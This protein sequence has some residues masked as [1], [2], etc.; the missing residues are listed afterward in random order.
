MTFYACDI[1]FDTI[2]ALD[3]HAHVSID[4][5]GRRWRTDEPGLSIQSA[6]SPL[7]GAIPTIDAVAQYYRER[8]MA[9]VVFTVDATAATGRAPNS[10]EEIAERA[11][12]NADVLIPFGS[13]DPW[14]GTA[15][16]HRAHRLAGEYGGYEGSNSIRV[17][18]HSNPTIDS[19]TPSTKPSPSIRC[20]CSST[21]ARPASAPAGPADAGSSSATPTR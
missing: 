10:V 12:L 16:V 20:P 7:A 21:P 9:A 8:N 15:S 11:A 5:D 2:D 14:Q 17:F 6:A 3:I 18:R 13:V 1:D 19:S 4:W